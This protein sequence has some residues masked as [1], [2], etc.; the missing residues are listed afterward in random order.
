MSTPASI[1]E[2]PEQV[3]RYWLELVD[4]GR[5]TESWNEAASLFRAAV[6]PADWTRQVAAARGPLG[7]VVSRDLQSEQR[8]TELPGAPDGEYA[9]L[10]FATSFTH[11]RAGVETVTPMRDTDGRWR[12]S[13]YFIR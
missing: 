13:G 9:V 3:A 1:A 12:V 4:A 2:E 10:Q 7:A 5:Y 8:A 6:T 11:K